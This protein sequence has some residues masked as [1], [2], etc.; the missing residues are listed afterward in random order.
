MAG[1]ATGIIVAAAI[2][3]L[4][5]LPVGIDAII[6]YA[7]GFAFGLFIFQAL[8][9]KDMLGGK[10]PASGQEQLSS[11]MAFDERGDGG[12]DS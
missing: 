4:L 3:S 1:D 9:M 5:G 7:A 10:L 8:F 12:N 11:R 6:E 2:T